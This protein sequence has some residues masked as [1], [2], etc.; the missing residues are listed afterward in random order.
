MSDHHPSEDQ[1]FFYEKQEVVIDDFNADGFILDIGGGGEG[2]IGQ[3]KGEQVIAID[4][5]KRELEEAAPG[6]LKIVMDARDLKFLIYT[7]DAVTA[8]FTLMYIKE[9]DQEK[10]FSEV[11]RVLA[12]EGQFFIWDVILSPRPDEVDEKKEIAA[13]PL[14]I[15]LPD[16][17]ISTGY[18]ARWPE[19]K[20]DLAYYVRLA[21]KA[22]FKV[23]TQK[24]HDRAL[25]LQLQK[26]QISE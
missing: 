15:K 7:F 19:K 1:I 2:V 16:K 26:P 11:F 9:P 22:G 23:V 10:I 21:E 20:Q 13:F 24:E 18:G 12:P 14:L 5:N 8:F 25:F 3:L 4:P 6:P 17:E